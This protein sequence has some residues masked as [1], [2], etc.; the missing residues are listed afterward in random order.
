MHLYNGLHLKNQCHVL[1]LKCLKVSN[2]P[3][4][5]FFP[6]Y[7]AYTHASQAIWFAILVIAREAV[8][9]IN[10]KVD[11]CSRGEL[12]THQHLCCFPWTPLLPVE[13]RMLQQLCF[14]LF[15]FTGKMRDS[16]CQYAFSPGRLMRLK[17]ETTIKVW[18][19]NVVMLLSQK[20]IILEIDQF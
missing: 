3:S 4:S 19:A 18:L 1:F 13:K 20:N 2:K 11:G 15:V 14:L 6:F 16:Y 7:Y 17:L 9:D 10:H 5:T 8:E 12:I